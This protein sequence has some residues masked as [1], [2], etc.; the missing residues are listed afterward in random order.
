MAGWH[1]VSFNHV[2]RVYGPTVQ[3]SKAPKAQFHKPGLQ[4]SYEAGVGGHQSNHSRSDAASKVRPE[5]HDKTGRQKK[6]VKYE[7]IDI[8]PLQAAI[9][10]LKRYRLQVSIGCARKAS[11]MTSRNA[12]LSRFQTPSL[13]HHAAY[14]TATAGTTTSTLYRQT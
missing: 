12:T 4:R 14:P 5:K 2:Y 8:S 11:N 7:H 6:D 3:G 10:T 9:E 13:T 1:S